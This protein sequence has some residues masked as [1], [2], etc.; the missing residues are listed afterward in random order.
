MRVSTATTQIPFWRELGSRV[1]EY[2]CRYIIQL[3]HS[4]RQRD[5]PGFEI[6]TALS[7]TKKADPLHGFPCESATPA[8][9]ADVAGQFAA[10][11]RRAREPGLDGVEIHAANGYI[12]T[13]FL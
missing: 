6:A 1:H 3:A 12:F 8:Q 2:D 5:I 4:G 9:L 11:A 7:S 10:A 13:Q